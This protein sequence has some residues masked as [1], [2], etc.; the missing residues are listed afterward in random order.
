MKT[1]QTPTLQIDKVIHPNGVPARLKVERRI[2]A[3]LLSRLQEK[4]F[5]IFSVHDEDD[6]TEVNNDVTAAMELIFN[7]DYAHVFVTYGEKDSE[8]DYEHVHQI[9]LVLGEGTTI[10]SDYTYQLY[11][12]DGFAIFMSE[13]DAEEFA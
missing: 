1:V 11:D 4:G 3:N 10:I 2:V 5:K 6:E 9:S 12:G 8:G 7:L 13:F